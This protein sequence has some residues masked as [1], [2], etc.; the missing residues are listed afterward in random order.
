M[1]STDP[2]RLVLQSVMLTLVASSL[3]ISPYAQSLERFEE[4]VTRFTM[5][6]GLKFIVLERHEAPVVSFHTYADVGSVDEVKGI[7]GMAHLF[8]H[9]AFKGSKGVGTKDYEAEEKAMTKMD[10]AFQAIK[11]ER[12]KGEQADAKRL[13]EPPAAPR[14]GPAGSRELS[15]P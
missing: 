6:N 8:E 1:H 5:K 3:V 15:C 10:A 12:R 13:Q 2:N 9:L 14:G 11:E 7:T 4:K